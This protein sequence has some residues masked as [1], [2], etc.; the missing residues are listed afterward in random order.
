MNA[1][2]LKDLAAK[3]RR[4]QAGRV[5]AGRIPGGNSYGYRIIREIKS[6]GTVTTGDRA[7]DESQAQVIRRK[8]EAYAS[9]QPPRRIAAMLNKECIPGPRGGFGNASPATAVAN[10]VMEFLIMSVTL[11]ASF[12]SA[13]I[14]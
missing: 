10:A 7:I 14:S 12:I 2:F 11:G 5:V 9:N 13:S 1:L 4:G 3:T 6:D 8:F